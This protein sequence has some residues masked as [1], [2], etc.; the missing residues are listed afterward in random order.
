MPEN[1]RTYVALLDHLEQ[2]N[3]LSRNIYTFTAAAKEKL[4]KTDPYTNFGAVQRMLNN[5]GARRN[6]V[7]GLCDGLRFPA[8]AVLIGSEVTE[9]V[10]KE[11]A[12]FS[13]RNGTLVHTYKGAE[14]AD[15]IRKCLYVPNEIKVVMT[16]EELLQVLEIL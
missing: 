10:Y 2:P 12:I 4:K 6:D 8:G 15:L 1:D 3:R 13:Y 5:F 7:P 9:D 14:H 16:T 11:T